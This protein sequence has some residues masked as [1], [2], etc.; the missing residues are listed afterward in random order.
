MSPRPARAWL[1]CGLA[2]ACAAPPGP[3][4]PEAWV[5]PTDAPTA[6]RLGWTC[7]AT[8]AAEVAWGPGDGEWRR[9]RTDGPELL[10]WGVPAG[11]TWYATV[12]LAGADGVPWTS[13]P[14]PL[15]APPWPEALPALSTAGSG[16]EGAWVVS[17]LVYDATALVLDAEGRPV[18]WYTLDDADRVL[19]V[20][21]D[22]EGAGFW[23]GVPPPAEALDAGRVVH[24]GLDGT[25][26]EPLAAAGFN[27]DLAPLPDGAVAINRF[28]ARE[29]DGEEVLGAAIV[30]LDRDGGERV[31]FTTW[32]ALDPAAEGRVRRDWVHANYLRHDAEDESYL[33][34]LRNVG[35]ILKV[36]RATGEVVWALGGATDGF[37]TNPEA[38]FATQH[39]F[40]LQGG[41]LAVYGNTWD[42]LRR[43]NAV[44]E[45]A[46][47]PAA[48]A[49]PEVWRHAHVPAL[50]ETA[51]GDV[52]R[53]ADGSRLVAWGAAGVLE[54]VTEDHQVTWS[55]ATDD[56]RPLGYLGVVEPW[57]SPP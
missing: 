14:L 5:T 34:G 52:R 11:E 4:A 27:H 25:V 44:V 46:L 57:L 31:V 28:D 38:L 47:D 19:T 10:A 6:F 2:A 53:L 9:V 29:V 48:G 32:D 35:T 21:P 33:F 49:A 56:G 42:T 3:P 15:A 22:V 37:G 43:G 17:S 40:D 41:R 18:W 30:E 23:L 8:C 51:Y 13:A 12:T 39:G 16:P 36:D 45:Y 54:R 7:P 1:A 26:E 55:V 50:Y 24:V 20:E